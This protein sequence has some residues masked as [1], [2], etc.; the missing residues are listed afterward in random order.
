MFRGCVN[1]TV[2]QLIK[3]YNVMYLLKKKCTYQ[4]QY[5]TYEQYHNIFNKR[6]TR[7]GRR[8]GRRTKKDN[9]VNVPYT[10]SLI[11][12]FYFQFLSVFVPYAYTLFWTN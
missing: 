4:K 2:E 11:F 6:E 3:N 12:V 9:K 1:S 5:C 10:L 8:N 7:K